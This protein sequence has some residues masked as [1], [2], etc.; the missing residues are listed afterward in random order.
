MLYWASAIRSQS[1]R[2]LRRL[3]DQPIMRRAV[4]AIERGQRALRQFRHDLDGRRKLRRHRDKRRRERRQQADPAAACRGLLDH[5][6]VRLEHRHRRLRAG[7][8]FDAGAERG[9]R[10]QDRVRTGAGGVASQLEES[11]GHGVGQPAVARE[12]RRQAVVEQ[13]HQPGVGPKPGE[14]RLDRHD[15]MFQ[16]V[17]ER[18]AHGRQCGRGAIGV[19]PPR[20]SKTTAVMPP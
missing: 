19:N 8:R 18:N 11:L 13:I 2:S 17:D 5:R 20:P 6:F 16:G 12:V 14:R 15:R 4:A 7:D 1:R 10:E 3:H 9:T